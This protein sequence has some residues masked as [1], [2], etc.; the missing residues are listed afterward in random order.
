MSGTD[1]VAGSSLVALSSEPPSPDTD[2][3][4]DATR[5]VALSCLVSTG[6]PCGVEDTTTGT[7]VLDIRAAVS[8]LLPYSFPFPPSCEPFPSAFMASLHVITSYVTWPFPAT[9]IHSS[10]SDCTKSCLRLYLLAF[11]SVHGI[12]TPNILKKIVQSILW[13]YSGVVDTGEYRTKFYQIYETFQD[14]ILNSK[15][16]LWKFRKFYRT[17]FCNRLYARLFHICWTISSSVGLHQFFY[18]TLFMGHGFKL[19]RGSFFC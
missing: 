19:Q 5:N 11:Q 3:W 8:S 4:G 2:S 10:W 17:L 9:K 7:G 18:F 13:N 1:L 15:I 16:F 14:K 6:F 12:S